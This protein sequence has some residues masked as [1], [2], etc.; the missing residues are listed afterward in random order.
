MSDSRKLYHC[1]VLFGRRD[2]PLLVL[3]AR[4]IIEKISL[5]SEKPLLLAIALKESG[6]DTTTFQTIINEL[7]QIA[8]WY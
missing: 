6:R 8:T 1:Q 2:D 4:Q 7:F 3:Y 5:V